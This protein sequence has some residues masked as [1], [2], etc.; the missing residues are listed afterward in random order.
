[1]YDRGY[2]YCSRCSEAFLT[3]SKYCPIC[4]RKMRIK[5]RKSKKREY[6]KRMEVEGV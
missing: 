1:M 3:R 6:V 4:G 2:K 5:G